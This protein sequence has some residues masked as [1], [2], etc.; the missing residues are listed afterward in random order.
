[1]KGKGELCIELQLTADSSKFGDSL[2]SRLD[3]LVDTIQKAEGLAAADNHTSDPFV[4]VIVGREEPLL[5]TVKTKTLDP[6]WEEKFQFTLGSLDD[7]VVFEVWY[8]FRFQQ[9]VSDFWCLIFEAYFHMSR[10]KDTLSADDF[11]GQVTDWRVALN[12]KIRLA[13]NRGGRCGS[14]RC[15]T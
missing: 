11:L 13:L 6:T 3:E 14:E 2:P 8:G 9:N 15:G 5:T 10:D 7:D 12:L 4:K 1:M